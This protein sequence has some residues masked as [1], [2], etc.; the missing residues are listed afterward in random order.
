MNDAVDV[1]L[2]QWARERPDLDTSTM[3]VHGRLT[4]ASRL[5]A[6]GVDDYLS[7]EGLESWEFDVLAT[8][9]RAGDPHCLS[10]KELV[11][12]TM[13]GS[14][15][16]THRVD[17]L[18][19]RGLVTRETDPGN[20]RRTLVALTPEGLELVDRVVEGHVANQARLLGGM[21]G[22]DRERLAELLRVLL[23]SL[24]DTL[25]ER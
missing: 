18:V 3:A 2:S 9:R 10:A 13:V 16:M 5:M 15:A 8:L 6:R 24:G 1:F 11:A 12:M 20:R 22:A 25:P 4:R 17:R 7:G 14:A 19:R 21:D 23:L